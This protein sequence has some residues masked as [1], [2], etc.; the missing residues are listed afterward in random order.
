MTL[1]VCPPPPTV[2]VASRTS[3]S[4]GAMVPRFQVTHCL[5]P[6]SV[7]VATDAGAGVAPVKDWRLPSNFRRA[8]TLVSG[9]TERL[10]ARSV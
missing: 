8:T 10:R 7:Q 2:K 9:S 5:V 6:S 1:V 3:S 4:A